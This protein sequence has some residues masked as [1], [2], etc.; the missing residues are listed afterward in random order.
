MEVILRKREGVDLVFSAPPS[1]SYTH[2]GLIAAALAEGGSH[3]MHP[4]QSDD[5]EVT[6]R[7]LVS[8]GVPIREEKD[9]YRISGSGG[10][11]VCPQGLEL[12]ME[13]SGTSYR[14]LTSVALLCRTPVVLTGSDRMKER[15]VGPLVAAINRLGGEAT[16][17]GTPGYPPI[18]VGGRFRGG[19]TVVEAGISSQFVSS[20]LLTG[21]YA[22]ED[23][24]IRVS[25][26]LV[27]P[28]Y[29]DITLDVM[30]SFGA[31]VERQGYEYFRVPAG[32]PYHGTE[33]GIEGD[34]SGASYFFA[35]AALCRGRVRVE[36]LNP[37]SCQGD[38]RFVT[39]LQAMGCRVRDLPSGMEVEYTGD[40]EGI[41]VDMST[42]PDT[43]QTLCMVA[44]MARTPSRIF[45]ISHLK[46]K[47][48]DRLGGTARLLRSLGGNV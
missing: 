45:G 11:L 4:L 7:A 46:W 48:S 26:G 20:L 8:M 24:E 18:R 9:G 6:R 13:N 36:N 27:S 37:R 43:V 22:Q 40:L 16:F 14:L 32:I 34:F 41:E 38:R 39:A 5:T 2:R 33:Y 21:P 15:P 23:V 1:K 17:L 28:S 31:H 19:N 44:A 3:V 42:S 30:G 47:E 29:L 25:P 10:D 12:D 35:L